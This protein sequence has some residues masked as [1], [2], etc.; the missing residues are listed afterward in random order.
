[1]GT[2]PRE[3]SDIDRYIATF[4]EEERR[5]LAAAEA[6]IDLAVLLHR[7]RARQGL[8]QAAA[9]ERAGFKQ[10]VVS[11]FEQPGANPQL[12]TLERYLRALGYEIA[13]T[14]RDQQT[15]EILGTA[16]LPPS[17]GRRTVAGAARTG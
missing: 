15:G 3:D 11:R 12:A 5:E 1:M 4:S 16:T 8:S 10:Q 7:A 14:I 6:A 13:V 2:Q 9:A 17:Q